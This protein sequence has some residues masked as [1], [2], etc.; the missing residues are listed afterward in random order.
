MYALIGWLHDEQNIWMFY[1]QPKQL[2]PPQ[3]SPPDNTTNLKK[4]KEEEEDV[5]FFTKQ[6]R[7]QDEA[8]MALAQVMST[9]QTKKWM[10]NK[11]NEIV[12]MLPK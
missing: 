6:A 9:V 3:K 10:K 1:L 8:R 12:P 2:Q 5:D 7:L 11:H 4:K